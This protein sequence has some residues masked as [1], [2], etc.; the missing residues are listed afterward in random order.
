MRQAKQES[1]LPAR[2]TLEDCEYGA[3]LFMKYI[4]DG[5]I[6]WSKSN[7]CFVATSTDYED[8][9]CLGAMNIE[10]IYYLSTHPDPSYW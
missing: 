1:N 5:T 6:W 3:Q 10:T 2:T 8:F 7:Q 9:V 4:V